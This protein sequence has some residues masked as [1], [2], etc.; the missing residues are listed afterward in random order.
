MADR[1]SRLKRKLNG[2]YIAWQA[3]YA[4]VNTLPFLRAP[5]NFFG[6]AVSAATLPEAEIIQTSTRHSTPFT[7][8]Q[9]AFIRDACG[10]DKG[11]YLSA[12]PPDYWAGDVT[13]S[14][15]YA[16]LQEATFYAHAGSIADKSR[17]V[18]VSDTPERPNWNHD[19]IR[20]RTQKTRAQAALS[21]PVRRYT[22][23]SHFLFDYALPV[24]RFL[25]ENPER[26][27][28]AAFYLVEGQPAFVHILITKVASHFGMS[29]HEIPRNAQLTA[30]LM[31]QYEVEAPCST[32]TCA[33]PELA[34]TVRQILLGSGPVENN[35]PWRKVYLH[36]D[37]AKWRNLDNATEIR[38]FMQAQ[39]F[40][41]FTPQQDNFLDQVQLMSET[42]VLVSAHGA[43][44]TNL[45]FMPVGGHVIEF[46][47]EDFAISCYLSAARFAGHAHASVCG[48]NTGG[49]QNYAIAEPALQS[50]IEQFLD[51]A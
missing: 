33:T 22:N 42:S 41:V 45:L 1:K 38:H 30:P 29:V 35:A 15:R 49:R 6:R 8:A 39:G 48:I 3:S 31:L 37:G 12:P 16:L 26:R 18:I 17:G 46:F 50:V 4:L 47:P 23:Y 32:W 28:G 13:V 2:R 51:S 44:L 21:I 43:A 7:D 34:A 10:D 40:E 9:Q 36:R 24:I 14:V 25:Q 27:Q 19:K 5:L 20:F 11:R